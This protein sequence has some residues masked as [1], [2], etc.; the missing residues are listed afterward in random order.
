VQWNRPGFDSVWFEIH[1]NPLVDAENGLLGISVVFFDVTSTRTLLDKVVVTNRQLESAY[2][3]L[4][5]TNEELETTNE[6][7]QST[8]EEL[9]TTNEELQSTNEELETMNEE[10]QSTND[11][12]HTINDT[13]GERSVE[14]D[15][16]RTFFD[17]LV[18]SVHAALIVVDREMHVVVWNRAAEELWGM[19]ADEVAGA[20]LNQLDIGLPMEDVKPMIGNAFVNPETPGAAAFEVINRRG[21]TVQLK[22]VCTA[23]RSATTAITGALLLLEPNQPTD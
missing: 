8:V 13:L 22:V 23:F 2:E 7:L 1:V 11:E 15:E 21:R 18:N 19:R 12:L 3:E 9:E 4:Q 17:S 16:A 10:L 14:L 5:S 6:E 20:A